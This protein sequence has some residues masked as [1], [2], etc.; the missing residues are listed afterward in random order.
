MSCNYWLICFVKHNLVKIWTR[1]VFE[2][3]NTCDMSKCCLYSISEELS[4]GS[5]RRGGGWRGAH[6]CGAGR[7]TAPPCNRP[8][9]HQHHRARRCLLLQLQ[10]AGAPW[11]S[12]PIR[13]PHCLPHVH[14]HRWTCTTWT[15]PRA[16]DLALLQM[17]SPHRPPHC[18]SSLLTTKIGTSRIDRS[19]RCLRAVW[20]VWTM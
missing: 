19:D 11:Q 7:P 6:G 15:L 17:T 8:T 4:G 12:A 5:G 18:D 2:C 14:R 16:H 3:Y 9:G 1:R 20:P 10:R 13:S